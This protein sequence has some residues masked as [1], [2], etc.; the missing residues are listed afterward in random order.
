MEKGNDPYRSALFY[1]QLQTLEDILV[2]TMANKPTRSSSINET[3][4]INIDRNRP[5]RSV[6]VFVGPGC[7]ADAYTIKN[8]C[9]KL[10]RFSFR[11]VEDVFRSFDIS[12]SAAIRQSKDDLEDMICLIAKRYSSLQIG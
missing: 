11:Q 10:E 9:E 7:Y 5:I 12:F 6:H 4:F 2:L 1:D 3:F 8:R